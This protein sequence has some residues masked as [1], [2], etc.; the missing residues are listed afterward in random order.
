MLRDPGVAVELA[1]RLGA[2][3]LELDPGRVG[4]LRQRAGGEVDGDAGVRAR[5]QQRG[6]LGLGRDVDVQ[7]HA[8][9]LRGATG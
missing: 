2:E 9:Q 1:Q 8:T 3:V 6:D 7:G 4:V 5:V